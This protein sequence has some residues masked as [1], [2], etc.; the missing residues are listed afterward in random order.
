MVRAII[1]DQK[2]IRDSERRAKVKTGEF[3][4]VREKRG[5]TQC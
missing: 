5:N 4:R 3:L 2:T 1:P